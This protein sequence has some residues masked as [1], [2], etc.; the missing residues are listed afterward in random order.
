MVLLLTNYTSLLMLA[1]NLM[2]NLRH[3]YRC[4][5]LKDIKFKL[6]NWLK[7]SAC[8]K[9]TNSY[10]VSSDQVFVAVPNSQ[11]QRR[12]SHRQ[13]NTRQLKKFATTA[14]LAAFAA[15]RLVSPVWLLQFSYVILDFARLA[16]HDYHIY[17]LKARSA[18]CVVLLQCH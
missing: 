14:S 11:R 12:P 7:A 8:L 16:Q 13:K 15:F 1:T 4:V 10:V 5:F 17:V 9:R 18:A 3:C 6:I 2:N